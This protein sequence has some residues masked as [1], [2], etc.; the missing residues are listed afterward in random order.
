MADSLHRMP[1]PS[2]GR[3]IKFG[4]EDAGT[5]AFCPHCDTAVV[6]QIEDAPPVEA[7]AGAVPPPPPVASNGPNKAMLIAIP[8]AAFVLVFGLITI[9]AVIS[10]KGKR[11]KVEKIDPE[12]GG[13]VEVDD[14]DDDDPPR[15]AAPKVKRLANYK[16]PLNLEKKKKI[17]FGNPT[18]RK[19][20]DATQLMGHKV[21]KAE[22]GSMQYVVGL[23]TNHTSKRFFDVYAHFDLYDDKKKK[24]G[25]AEDYLGILPPSGSWELKATIFVRGA[26]SAKL[27][28]IDKDAE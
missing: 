12:T 24:V 20:G 3:R 2:C 6:L 11:A 4:E 25:V 16:R 13:V 10:K 1:C 17:A 14:N 19:G 8:V 22:L 18:P 7:D 27:R 15:K 5:E 9:A 28:T 23:V 21:I 26:T